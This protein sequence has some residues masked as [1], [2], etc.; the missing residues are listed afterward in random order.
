MVDQLKRKSTAGLV[1]PNFVGCQR[2]TVTVAIQAS[3][4]NISLVR[5]SAY[6]TQS[7]SCF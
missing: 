5:V 6:G 1:Y 3:G 4:C 7:S 2:R